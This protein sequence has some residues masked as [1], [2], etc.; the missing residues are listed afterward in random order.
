MHKV[1]W[2]SL[3]SAFAAVLAAASQ[4]FKNCCQLCSSRAPWDCS[5]VTG[6]PAATSSAN[7]S[8]YCLAAASAAAASFLPAAGAGGA[9][10]SNSRPAAEG[11]ALL[12]EAVPDCWRFGIALAKHVAGSLDPNV[13]L[14]CHAHPAASL[15]QQQLRQL[16]HKPP[17]QR[18]F[19]QA[20]TLCSPSCST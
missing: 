12:L 2:K 16:L 20:G 5:P 6:V 8:A 9:H 11:D 3:T 17:V 15:F 18:V 19:R 7:F 1:T 10:N 14:T 13:F 4:R